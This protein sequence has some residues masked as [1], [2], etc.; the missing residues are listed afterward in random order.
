LVGFLKATNYSQRAASL[1]GFSTISEK[2]ARK[3]WWMG[4]YF[5]VMALKI[6]C[7][8]SPP[9]KAQIDPNVPEDV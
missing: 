9:K 5:P 2:S 7:E 4:V 1:G 6:Y 8:A 3:Y